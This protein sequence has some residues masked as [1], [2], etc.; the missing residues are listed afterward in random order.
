[1]ANE[2]LEKIVEDATT[3]VPNREGFAYYGVGKK[4]IG[5]RMPDDEDDALLMHDLIHA[6]GLSNRQLEDQG[7]SATYVAAMLGVREEYANRLAMLGRRIRA[8]SVLELSFGA[9]STSRDSLTV[10]S[11]YALK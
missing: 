11:E 3:I 8:W 6:Q 5:V 10:C 9:L 4:S 7:H 2:K 1:M